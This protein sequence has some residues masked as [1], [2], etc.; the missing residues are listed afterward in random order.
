MP[1]SFPPI[2]FF[3]ELLLGRAPPPWDGEPRAAPGAAPAAQPDA[4]ARPFMLLEKRKAA[5]PML[6]RHLETKSLDEAIAEIEKNYAVNGA[7]APPPAAAADGE[8]GDAS[9]SSRKAEQKIREL[10][11]RA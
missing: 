11:I 5:A 8:L 7:P 2:G 9:I 10:Q 1:L 3:R 6:L 4:V